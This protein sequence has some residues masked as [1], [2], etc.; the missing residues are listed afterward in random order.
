M[1]ITILADLLAL[2][3]SRSTS[4]TIYTPI[5]PTYLY[6]KQHSVTGLKYF[7]KTTQDPYKYLGSGKHWTRHIKKHG[8]EHIVTLWVS[9][10]FHDTSIVDQALQLSKEHNIVES[11]EWA[12]L[13]P[14]N[15]LDGGWINGPCSD[16]RKAKLRNANIGKTY[17]PCSDER[18]AK[19]SAKAK[20]RPVSSKTRA[21]L[22]AAAKGKPH[23]KETKAKIS[24]AKQNISDETRAKLAKASTGRIISDE[25]RA[26][27]SASRKNRPPASEETRAKL[28]A[29]NKGK[30]YN[31][32]KKPKL[33]E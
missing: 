31:K 19:I 15:G 28:S 23:S 8:K 10:L 1:P 14:E 21:K 6:I 4:M 17:G 29:A 13:K 33:E 24:I 11:K 2:I 27:M 20:G 26:K 30:T 3:L 16:E 18:K 7:G 9:E 32:H 22:S 25:T 12:N 5:T